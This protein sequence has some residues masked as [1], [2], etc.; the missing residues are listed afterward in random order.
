MNPHKKRVMAFGTFDH[1]HAGHEFYLKQARELG[2][3]L[4][5]VL[6][7]D[8]TANHIRG[9]KPDHKERLRLKAVA[10]LPQVTKAVLGDHDDKY[11][12]LKKY[13]PDV[14]ALG[15][16]QYVFTH[17]LSK[18]LIDLN[19]NAEIVRLP[20]FEPQMY[21]SSLIRQAKLEKIAEEPLVAA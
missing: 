16:D 2:E 18:I 14:I 1:M 20:P 12:V 9:F 13:K 17:N 6:A 15:Y 3:E 11:K 5:V 7:R 4:V 10:A 21:K 8:L 19:L